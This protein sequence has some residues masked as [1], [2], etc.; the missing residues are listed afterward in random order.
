MPPTAALPAIRN[1]VAASKP[2]ARQHG[3]T[4]LY[5]FGSMA[6]GT[7][8]ETSDVDLIYEMDDSRD[9]RE[10]EAFRADLRAV[11]HREIDLVRK[12]YLEIPKTD[13]YERELQDLFIRSVAKGPLIRIL[14][15]DG[16]A[17]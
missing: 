11:L 6:K 17:R 4:A 3:V 13:P 10:T 7:A 8:T 16:D 1:I 9:W 14:P 15:D 5:L 12:S 2:L